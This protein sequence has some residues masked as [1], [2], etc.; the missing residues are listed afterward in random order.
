[1]LNSKSLEIYQLQDKK[2]RIF[3]IP[4]VS[5]IIALIFE[6]DLFLIMQLIN[7]F[8]KYSICFLFTFTFWEGNRI[9]FIKM[10]QTY[11]DYDSTR[12]RL[13]LQTFFSII[14]TTVSHFILNFFLHNFLLKAPVNF[15]EHLIYYWTS[16]FTTLLVTIVYECFYFFDEW[17]RAAVE[18][19]KLKR[20]NL[21][22][23]FEMLKNQVNPHFLFN[24]LNTLIT[25]IPEDTNLAV[26]FVQKLSKVYRYVLH[27]KNK[28]LIDLHTELGFIKD[29]VFLNKIRFGDNLVVNFKIPETITTYMV[30]PL[31]IQML[32]ENAIK[33]NVISTEKPLVIDVYVEKNDTLIIKNNLQKK[34]SG[35]ESTQVGLQNIINRYKFLTK[36]MVDVIVTTS[37]FMVTLPLLKVEAHQKVLEDY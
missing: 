19:E 8:T 15:D 16:L 1:M 34:I 17:K 12:K 33:H 23:Q 10:R 22:S 25:I 31:T 29:Y 14:F 2:V 7:F 6:G 21:I 24:S 35:V 20:E 18:S 9:I 4:L 28:E 36:K 27:H 5:L 32:I 30:A 37:S 3:G 11:R 13:I 26:E